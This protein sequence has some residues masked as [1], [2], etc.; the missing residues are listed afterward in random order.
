M[1]LGAPEELKKNFT[2][3]NSRREEAKE[4]DLYLHRERMALAY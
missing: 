4:E 1:K 2:T 3:N